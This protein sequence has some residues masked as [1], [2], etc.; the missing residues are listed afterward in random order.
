LTRLA[1]GID[2][3]LDGAFVA[4]DEDG[5]LIDY[6]DMALIIHRKTW[7][8]GPKKGKVSIKRD[9]NVQGI[10][11]LLEDFLSRHK[12]YDIK[13][14]LERAHAIPKQGL[15][16][17]FTTGRGFGHLEMLTARTMLPT[18]IIR[19]VDWQKL[20]L[21]GVTGIDTKAKSLTKAA[22]KWPT[23][24][25]TRPTGK[26]PCMDGRSDAA[27]MANYKIGHWNE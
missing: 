25:L 3:G 7:T 4:I 19:A 21:K 13:F 12:K 26:V 24:V 6:W 22:M 9:F 15:G 18:Q 14:I 23:L 16:S 2:G 10:G 17:T 20:E 1:V 5:K 11:L 8:R 27:H